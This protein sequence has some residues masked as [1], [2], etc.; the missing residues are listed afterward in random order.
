MI[1]RRMIPTVLVAMAIATPALAYDPITW[2]SIDGGG[3]AFATA[4]AYKLGGTIGQPDAGMLTGGAYTLRGGFWFG[5]ASHSVGVADGAPAALAFALYP[6]RP[7]PVRAQSRVAFDLPRASHVALAVFDV[8]GR[9]V[10]RWDFGA[11]PAGHQE[12]AWGAVDESG[13]PLSSGVYFLRLDTDREHGVQ[14][15]LVLR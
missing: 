7:N 4:G 11:L 13:R 10:R 6:T 1:R 3:V 5:G 14:K 2:S 9:A 15:V 8:S 12:R